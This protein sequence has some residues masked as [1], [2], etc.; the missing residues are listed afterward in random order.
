MEDKKYILINKL[1]EIELIIKKDKD[2]IN[3]LSTYKQL[4][5][6]DEEKKDFNKKVEICNDILKLLELFEN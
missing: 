4:R 3:S 2:L 1:K 6:F 5:N